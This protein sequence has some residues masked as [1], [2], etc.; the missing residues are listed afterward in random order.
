MRAKDDEELTSVH[1]G[2]DTVDGQLAGMP[3]TRCLG[4]AEVVVP[5]VEGPAEKFPCG[6]GALI[7]SVKLH[8]DVG[9]DG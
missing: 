6:N 7:A 8:A 4:A 3:C 5:N 2:W 9:G 1:V